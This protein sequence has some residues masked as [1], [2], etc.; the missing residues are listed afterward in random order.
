MHLTH[1]HCILP[2]HATTPK[3]LQRYVLNFAEDISPRISL[4]AEAA[5]SGEIY[6]S[7]SFVSDFFQSA[8]EKNNQNL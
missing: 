6:I 2:R 5:A 3:T 4:S 7:V 8:E 1:I